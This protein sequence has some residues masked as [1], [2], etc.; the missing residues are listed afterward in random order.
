M[1][2]PAGSISEGA[3][4]WGAGWEDEL[5][6][7]TDWLVGDWAWTAGSKRAA[8]RGPKAAVSRTE[9]RNRWYVMKETLPFSLVRRAGRV[10]REAHAGP[11]TKYPAWI[12]GRAWSIRVPDFLERTQCATVSNRLLCLAL[13]AHR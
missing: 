13:S 10:K 4:S 9:V 12:A 3:F 5:W 11:K 6:F 8:K 7:R 1:V 2:G